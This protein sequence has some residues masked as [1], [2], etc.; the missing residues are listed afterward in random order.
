[1]KT[2]HI[3][4]YRDDHGNP[5]MICATAEG[6]YTIAKDLGEQGLDLG[7]APTIE[8][9][10]VMIGPMGSQSAAV[11]PMALLCD[12]FRQDLQEFAEGKHYEDFGPQPVDEDV[13]G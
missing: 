11:V 13:D 2:D 12:E 8:I 9:T 7:S 5:W 6:E 3:F 10:A 4:E 1:M